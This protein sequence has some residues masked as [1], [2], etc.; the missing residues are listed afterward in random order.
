MKDRLKAE[1][2]RLERLEI[3]QKEEAPTDWISSLVVV[4]K[5]NGKLRVCI[6]PQPLNKALKRSQYQMPILDDILPELSKAK[7]FSVLDVKNGYWHVRLD[8][9]SSKLTTFNT[10]YGR[11]RWNRLPFGI[12]PAPE[13][14][15]R[16]LDNAIHG[17][18]GI[19]TIADDILVVGS[20][21]TH[22]EARKDHDENLLRLLQRCRNQGIKLNK[23]KCY[24]ATQ[25]VAYMGHV[26]TSQGIKP[27]DDK[28]EAIVKMPPPQDV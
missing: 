5:Q 12:T 8:E 21:T 22:D 16:A 3:I 4:K 28:I 6:D 23:D 20:G 27:D 2:Q 24:I 15:Q 17:L 7:I 18:A 9:P 26:L 14:F 19:Y 25:K 1:L 11:Y 10:P 13:I